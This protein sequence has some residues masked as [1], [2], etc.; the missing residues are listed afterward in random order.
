M[1]PR[2]LIAFTFLLTFTGCTVGPHYTPS[3][4]V[5]PPAFAPQPA[6]VASAPT[7]GGTVDLNWWDSFHDAELSSLIH[8]LAKQNLDIQA[9]AERVLEARAV[10]KIA[11]SASLPQ[12]GANASYVRNRA[13]PNG[14]LELITPAPGAPLDYNLFSD[15]LQSSWDLDLF[16][17][18]RRLTEAAGAESDAAVEDRR[19]LVLA[20]AAELAQDYMQLRGAQAREAVLRESLDIA[21]RGLALV[22]DQFANGVATKAD[23][24]IAE[25]QRDSIL[26]LLPPVETEKASLINAIG[27]LLALEPRALDGELRAPASQPPVPLRVPVGLPGEL[28]RRR[29]DVRE[30]EA[31]LHAATAETGAAVAS[32]YPDITLTGV[33]GTQGLQSGNIFDFPSRYYAA[34]PMLNLPLFTG[35]Q[36]KGTLELR[37][38]QQREAG[39]HFRQTVLVAWR[40]ADDAMTAYVQAQK[41]RDAIAEAVG[42][43]EAALRSAGET[44]AQGAADQR[45]VLTATA[46]L[47][48][49][50]QALTA[51]T[52]QVDTTLVG[53]Y[54]ALGGGWETLEVIH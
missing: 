42:K 12:I 31:M 13:S 47:L 34:G 33:A 53:L 44:F 48:E 10:R 40:E 50:R 5:S 23:V 46:A 28:V 38:A 51:A 7:F 32:F 3:Q 45:T 36:L 26:A 35:G 1:T 37:K 19:G 16:G 6:G 29:P 20:A 11:H 30:A 14:F 52:T 15:A 4:V 43:D 9:A 49:S 54:R 2:I 25:A 17:R 41:Q 39:L 22:E 8:R 27:D 24:A 21:S 18:L